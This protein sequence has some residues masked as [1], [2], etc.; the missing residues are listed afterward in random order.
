MEYRYNI[1]VHS[2]PL[3]AAA[4]R[5]VADYYNAQHDDERVMLRYSASNVRDV[6]AYGTV[7][8]DD[9]AH[10]AELVRQYHKLS[11]VVDAPRS[12]CV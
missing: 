6:I 5:V 7:I 2:T 1:T 11:A 4:R 10:D 9:D 8:L 12:V 3:L